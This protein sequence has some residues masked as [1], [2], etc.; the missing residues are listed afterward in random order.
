[1]RL[2][3]GSIARI[4]IEEKS[5][6]FPAPLPS[7]IKG[8]KRRIF[9]MAHTR[10]QLHAVIRGKVQGV[11]YR[12]WT[13]ETAQALG[14]AGWV[15]NLPDGAV[16]LLAEGEDSRLAELLARCRRGP[17]SARVDTIEEEWSEAAGNFS[18]FEIMR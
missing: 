10:K 13:V 18:K 16:E 5:K 4:F 11:F 6:P 12:T 7:V 3:P 9:L 1:M 2:V 8:K 14:L 17:P 15:K